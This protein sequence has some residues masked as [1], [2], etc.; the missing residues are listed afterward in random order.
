MFLRPHSLGP[1]GALHKPLFVP[2]AL[3]GTVDYLYSR[4]AYEE[5][6]GF[7]GA[8][9]VLNAVECA[10]Y[11]AYV[12][13][14]VPLRGGERGK[15]TRDGE[16]GGAFGVILGLVAAAMT[17]SK[18]CLYCRCLFFVVFGGGFWKGREWGR[19]E[20]GKRGERFRAGWWLMVCGNRVERVV[21][22]LGEH[23]T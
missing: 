1:D 7:T 16:D 8:Q 2:Y 20:K 22:G 21:F 11:A 5:R 12:W 23:R 18:T 4:K 19:G 3:Y 6:V 9:A 14:A 15:R 10:L 17:I 13:Y